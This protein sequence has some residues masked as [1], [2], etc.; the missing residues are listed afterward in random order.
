MELRLSEGAHAGVALDAHL[1]LL[2]GRYEALKRAADAVTREQEAV[3]SAREVGLNDVELAVRLRTGQDEAS[4]NF[5]PGD[6]HG[7][8]PHPLGGVAA[9]DTSSDAVLLPADVVEG[10]NVTV[11]GLGSGKVDA[12]SKLR[13]TRRQLLYMEWE[14]AYVRATLTHVHALQRDVSLM[15]AVGVVREFIEG[16]NLPARARGDITRA[17][18]A[19]VQLRRAHRR[20][21]VLLEKSRERLAAEVEERR[22][23]VAALRARRSQDGEGVAIQ[24]AL[25]ASRSA[26]APPAAAAGG[27]GKK[28]PAKPLDK[29]MQSVLARAQLAAA[30]KAQA[31]EL[32]ALQEESAALQRR[33]F[34]VLP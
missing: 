16:A 20:S 30:A 28:P 12:L 9:P 10:V 7:E 17:E 29:K 13:D 3:L 21:M 32:R 2:S 24:E 31:A 14:T 4:G 25:L 27:A 8:G 6:A 26:V 5:P 11:R 19:L 34:A 33:N 1:A 15:R 22:A 18:A 23:A